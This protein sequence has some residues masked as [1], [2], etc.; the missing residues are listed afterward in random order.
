MSDF[1][2]VPI[3]ARKL[4]V[5]EST[6]KRMLKDPECALLGVRIYR[7]AIRVTRESF[8]KHL[9]KIKEKSIQF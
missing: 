7:A 1:L 2:E 8:D 9:E 4:N 6:V 5:S 3:V